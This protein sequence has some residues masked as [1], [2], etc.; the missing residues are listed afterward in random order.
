[1]YAYTSTHLG[2]KEL[3]EADLPDFVAV[4]A[5]N[6]YYLSF[7]EPDGSIDLERMR[8]EWREDSAMPGWHAVG[9]YRLGDGRPVGFIYFL[10]RHPRLGVPHIGLFM[11][12]Q[13]L[14]GQGHGTE[15]LNGFLE[16][17]RTAHGWR[18]VRIGV[19]AENQPAMQFW[20]RY[21]F[22]I[23]GESE[24]ELLHGPAKILHM[25]RQL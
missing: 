3:T 14:H 2:F 11:V 24:M 13:R 15:A 22:A 20:T 10:E 9:F 21:G 18:E 6:T 16:Y 23:C 17:Q 12:D 25:T 5:S 1:M 19:I 7:F 4:N 8:K